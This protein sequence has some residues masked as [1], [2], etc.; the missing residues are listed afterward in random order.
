MLFVATTEWEIK[1]KGNGKKIDKMWFQKIVTKVLINLRFRLRRLIDSKAPKPLEVSTECWNDLAKWR[2]SEVS[3]KRSAQMRLISR[4]RASKASQ[5]QGLREVALVSLVSTLPHVS[6]HIQHVRYCGYSFQREHMSYMFGLMPRCHCCKRLI[7]DRAY[8]S[9]E[10][11]SRQRSTKR[12]RRNTNDWRRSGNAR[13]KA[14]RK[15]CRYDHEDGRI[16]GEGR[17]DS[18]MA[19]SQDRCIPV[20]TGGNV[21]AASSETTYLLHPPVSPRENNRGVNIL[22]PILADEPRNKAKDKEV[23]SPKLTLPVERCVAQSVISEGC[24]EEGAKEKDADTIP[25]PG[26]DTVTTGAG[27]SS[28]VGPEHP[29]QIS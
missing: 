21:P 18:R 28:G 14:Q 5:M 26:L 2:A 8:G 6:F 16:G 10:S 13:M 29:E 15:H 4:R 3:K 9:N 24:A 19:R 12:L 11:R 1:G 23:G 22:L 20:A 27:P 7:L 25:S 17:C